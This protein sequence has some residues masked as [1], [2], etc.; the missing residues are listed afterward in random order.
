M[1]FA[2]IRGRLL[3]FTTASIAMSAAIALAGALLVRWTHAGD[4]RV[5]TETTASLHRSHV[6][7]DQLVGAQISLQALLRLKDPDE[8]EAGL[9][10]YENAQR[11]AAAQLTGLPHEVQAPFA[12]IGETGKAIINDVLTANNASALQQFIGKYNPQLEEIVAALRRHTAEVERS[13][14]AGIAARQTATERALTLAA[15]TV[16]VF[17]LALALFA[18]RF[19]RSIARPLAGMAGRLGIAADSLTKLSN[20]V[21]VSS[22]T[23]SDG[24]SSQAASLEETS[25]S[26]EEIT[27]MIKRNATNSANGTTIAKQ[28]R[29][30]A[31]TGAADMQSMTV[32][33]DAIK[34]ASGNIG[35]II[36]TIDEIAFQT[37]ILALNAAVEAARAGEAG[38]G[39]AVV[40]E[41][42][43]NL[44]QR[45]AQA[46]RETAEKIED[47]I[48][49]SESGAV[50]SA[51]VGESLLTI[52]TRA[53]E[54]D[55]LVAEIAVASNEQSQ[56]INH[57]LT[58]V[59]EMDSVTQSNA[60]SAEESAA[61]TIEMNNEV[62]VL[63]SAVEELRAMLGL[64]VAASPPAAKPR[65][66]AQLE[67]AVA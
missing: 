56:G 51:K 37:N 18:W 4:S 13:A 58:A 66:R 53:R 62:R 22:Q 44:A 19:Q 63:R 31:D 49:K 48:H 27:S 61:A 30:A 15:A 32:A 67:S 10:R 40:A 35:K 54:V 38:L 8:I 33:M 24:A 12:K 52:V 65:E 14:T 6:A 11:Q 5:A 21:T 36:K 34:S 7:L 46:A 25:A 28:T 41:E 2:S 3:T 59:N 57:V 1:H 17:I 55:E 60:A 9:K 42:V 47:S 45:S 20:A 43:R 64:T 16:G 50:I 29:A 23:V 39:F 26:L